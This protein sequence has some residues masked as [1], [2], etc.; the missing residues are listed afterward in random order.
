MSHA[1][2][3]KDLYHEELYMIPSS[4]L[5][6]LPEAWEALPE[7]DVTT[8]TKMI[9]AL[10]LSM[11]SVRIITQQQFSIADLAAYAPSQVIALGAVCHDSPAPYQVVHIGNTALVVA[12]AL[13]QLDDAKKKTLWLA[14]KQMFGL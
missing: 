3:L 8:L 4:V 6:V 9:G 12:E 2:L 11:A 1:S 10:R 14:L 13:H 5:F 7:S